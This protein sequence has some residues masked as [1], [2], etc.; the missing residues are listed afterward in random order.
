MEQGAFFEGK[1]RRSENPLS[2]SRTTAENLAPGE[3][4]PMVQAPKKQKE[5]PEAACVR[6]LPEPD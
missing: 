1:S 5:K 6:A 3:P 2:T 4:Q